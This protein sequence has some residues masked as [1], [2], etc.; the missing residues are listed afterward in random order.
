MI[1]PSRVRVIRTGWKTFMLPLA[2]PRFESLRIDSTRFISI[3]DASS[4]T[5]KAARL[6]SEAVVQ[7]LSVV[8]LILT[9]SGL[10]FAMERFGKGLSAPLAKALH[11]TSWV[12]V[13]ALAVFFVIFIVKL[14]VAVIRRL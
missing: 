2:R 8:F 14:V 5:N 6:I 7:L 9:G 1:R 11:V 10:A 3:Q 4:Q 12:I 13:V